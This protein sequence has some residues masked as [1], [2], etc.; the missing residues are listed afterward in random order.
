MVKVSIF[1][2]ESQ[3]R[4]QYPFCGGCTGEIPENYAR[5]VSFAGQKDKHAVTEQWY[6]LACQA[7]KCP[8]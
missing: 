8:I 4:L 7:R 6:A 5:E 1:W 2:L 3:K